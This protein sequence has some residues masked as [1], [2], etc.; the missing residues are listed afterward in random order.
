MS[1][2][3]KAITPDD[4]VLPAPAPASLLLDW[5]WLRSSPP[6]AVCVASVAALPAV[7]GP[8]SVEEGWAGEV[9]EV[10]LGELRWVGLV[11]LA[12]SRG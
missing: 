1:A 8:A 2:S 10:L 9:A 5:V 11:V 3:S 6:G 4:E 7:D 12:W